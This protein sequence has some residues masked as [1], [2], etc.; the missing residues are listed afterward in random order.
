MFR[1]R[2]TWTQFTH[3]KVTVF[4]RQRFFGGVFSHYINIR[5]MAQEQANRDESQQESQRKLILALF[6][7][8]VKKQKNYSNAPAHLD[9]CDP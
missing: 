5:Q 3:V 2:Q 6:T 7:A 8:S 4:S 1:D 9:L